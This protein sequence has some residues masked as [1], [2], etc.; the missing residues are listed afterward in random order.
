[1]SSAFGLLSEQLIHSDRAIVQ[2][3]IKQ[4]WIDA[5]SRWSSI[6]DKFPSFSGAQ[7]LEGLDGISDPFDKWL[8]IQRARLVD[9]L[10]G[11][12]ES[13]LLLLRSSDSIPEQRAGAARLLI[14]FEPTHEGASRVLMRAL[15]E[16]GD[17]ALALQ[18]Y[19]RCEEALNTTLGIEP[20]HE[21]RTLYNEL[22]N[23]VR[24]DQREIKSEPLAQPEQFKAP[25]V[26]RIQARPRV[27]V[28][29]FKLHA[30]KSETIG[31]LLNLKIAAALARF[32]W[33]DVITPL[34]TTPAPFKYNENSQQCRDVNYVVEGDLTGNGE[35]FQVSVRLFDVDGYVRPVWSD[36]FD[37][38][39][40]MLDR[41]DEFVISPVAARI[42][43]IILSAEGQKSHA[44]HFEPYRCVPHAI[45]LMLSME[46]DKFDTAGQILT[47]MAVCDPNDSMVAAWR[48]YWHVFYWGQ[49][50][51]SDQAEALAVA[52]ELALK[53]I[54][55]DPG[56][57]E[58]LA[59]YAHVCA[60][61]ESDFDSALH[62]FDRALQINA[63]LAFIWALSAPTYCYIGEPDLA[64]Q[65]LQRYRELTPFDPTFPFWEYHCSAAYTFK[66]DYENAVKLGRR[67][68][69]TNPNFTNAYKSLIASLG[70]LGRHE[71]AKPYVDKLL[72][73]E[74]NFTVEGFGRA[75]PFRHESDRTRYMRG[76]L[77]AGIPKA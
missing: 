14:A 38:N 16:M 75:Y 71:E 72:T 63:N 20:S 59:I 65:R 23:S 10:R 28:L 24:S 33:F 53:A 4:C 2:F 5:R 31:V 60:F 32:R 3:N 25:A 17:R 76:L 18:E 56:N 37:L 19:G 1:L 51:A 41:V 11:F 54:R 66:A 9:Q 27:E 58:A 50:W 68:V 64:L 8:I 48:A 61:L 42:N 40:E 22:K 49:G 77:L 7:L 57:A 34:S 73:L 12:L 55:G 46:R 29:P 26:R 43:P 44:Q 69:K 47:E 52:Q 30:P 62:Y 21:T 74:P 6:L 15:I 13:E 67:A 39:A 35:N 36:R 45:Q 70:H